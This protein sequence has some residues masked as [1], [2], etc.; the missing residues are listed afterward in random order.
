M[1]ISVPYTPNSLSIA[2][3]ERDPVDNHSG[4]TSPQPDW[5]EMPDYF[6]F[7]FSDMQDL[8]LLRISIRT[9]AHLASPG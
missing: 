2:A 8:V 7:K 3:E 4:G 5:S 1:A 9:K 6:R